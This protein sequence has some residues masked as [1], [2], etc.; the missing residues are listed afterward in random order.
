MGGLALRAGYPAPWTPVPRSYPDRDR[1]V[2]VTTAYRDRTLAVP[3][4]PVELRFV[5]SLQ[6]PDQAAFEPAFDP[7]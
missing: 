5:R 4:P 6:A 3:K 7:V 2:A 1:T